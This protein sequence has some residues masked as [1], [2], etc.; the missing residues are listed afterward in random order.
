[1]FQICVEF[2]ISVTFMHEI[3][4]NLSKILYNITRTK[5]FTIF[6]I[7]TSYFFGA[8][9]HSA[10]PELNPPLY[11]FFNKLKIKGGLVRKRVNTQINEP[12]NQKT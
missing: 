10:Y 12:T 9:P 1:M 4:I 7:W 8:F 5:T 6:D 11:F 2:L 3:Q